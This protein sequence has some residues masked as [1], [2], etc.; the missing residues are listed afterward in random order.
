MKFAHQRELARYYSMPKDFVGPEAADD[1]IYMHEKMK[2]AKGSW[3]YQF[4]A[5]SAAAESGLMATHLGT[6]TRHDRIR[7]ADR[8]WKAAQDGFIMTHMHD[9]WSESRLFTVPD[10]IEMHRT[11]LELYHDMADS[12][13]ST[14]TLRQTHQRLVGIATSN[15]DHHN[16][17]QSTGDYSTMVNRRGLAYEVGT[18]LTITRL[19]CP[20][21]FAVPVPARADHG[22]YFPEKTHDVRLIQQTWGEINWCIPYEVKP[23]DGEYSSRYESALVRGRVELL[24]PSSTEPLDIARYMQEE[25]DGTISSAH[26]AELDEITSRVFRLAQDYKVRQAIAKNALIAV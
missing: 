8:S 11:Y 17:A 16:I 2:A 13:V 23:V 24:M 25:I 21:L 3:A 20:S 14:E 22:Q 5:G 15:L 4:V 7:S 18:L 6:E 9:G 19:Q 10:R 26:L 1:L 12:A